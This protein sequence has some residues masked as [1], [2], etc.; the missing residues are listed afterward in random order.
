MK[1]IKMKNKIDIVTRI[2]N[3][4]KIKSFMNCLTI[5]IIRK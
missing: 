3:E 2:E 5:A 1:K 4:Y